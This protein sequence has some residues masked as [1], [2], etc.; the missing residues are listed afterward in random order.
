MHSL[1]TVGSPHVGTLTNYMELYTEKEKNKHPNQH[2]GFLN[3][4]TICFNAETET[5]H[6]GCDSSYTM[7]T[8]FL[9]K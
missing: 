7:I 5:E 3:C 4:H 6:T 9:I 2:Y 1:P 8:M